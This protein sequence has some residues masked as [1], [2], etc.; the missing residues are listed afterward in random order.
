LRKGRK[1]RGK[2]KRKRKGGKDGGSFF[3]DIDK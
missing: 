1:K 2:E 3:G